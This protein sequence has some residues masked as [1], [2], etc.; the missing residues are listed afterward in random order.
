M[1]NVETC[2][3]HLVIAAPPESNSSGG[4]GEGA[5]VSCAPLH[6][7]ASSIICGSCVRS[8]CICTM[9]VAPCV[10]WLPTKFVVGLACGRSYP[11]S[12]PL[13]RPSACCVNAS[14]PVEKLACDE[15]QERSGAELSPGRTDAAPSWI[16]QTP[17][18]VHCVQRA[19]FD[20]GLRGIILSISG[21][22][23]ASCGP[24]SSAPFLPL[25]AGSRL[26]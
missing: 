5:S 16:E 15:L 19:P 3:H 6:E 18:R 9:S 14:Y 23:Y 25:A 13:S 2:A 20:K 1:K 4:G 8:S 22:G 21:N 10:M 26:L 17:E 24:A 11:G 7:L 12:T